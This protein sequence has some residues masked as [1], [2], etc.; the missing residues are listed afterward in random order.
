MKNIMYIVFGI[1]A[2][3]LFTIT[4]ANPSYA[5]DWLILDNAYVP[6]IV[7]LY[8]EWIVNKADPKIKE[9]RWYVMTMLKRTVE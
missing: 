1:F 7:K 9:K 4:R 5:S 3:A 6:H 8:N 2:L